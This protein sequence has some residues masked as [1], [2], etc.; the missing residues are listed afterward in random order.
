MK[1]S[2]ISF[3]LATLLMAS[4]TGGV[5]AGDD[6]REHAVFGRCVATLIQQTDPSNLDSVLFSCMA[7]TSP[8]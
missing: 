2:L 5:A 3:V 4:V 1:R 8:G 6:E 7:F